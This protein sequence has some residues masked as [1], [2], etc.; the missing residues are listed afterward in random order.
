MVNV[1]KMISTIRRERNM[2]QLE[3]SALVGASKQAISNYE[4]GIREPDYA[5]LEAIADALN[6]PVSMLI[7]RERQQEALQAIYN[8]YEPSTPRLPANLRPISNMRRQ[9]VPLI[10]QVAAGQPI[11]A[12]TDYET[13]VDAPIDCDVA[14]EVKGDSMV[15][16]YMPGDTVYIKCRP[17]VNEGQVA[18]VLIDDE[19]TLKHV[20]KRPTGLTLISDNPEYAPIMV[21]ADEHEYIAIYGV[22]VGFTRIFKNTPKPKKKR[23]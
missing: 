15:P 5:T 18:V 23:K 19:A 6:V 17:D 7:S 21:E 22:P 11:L 1:G 10:G 8:T 9:R 4:R 2:S 14:L 12:E 3:L 20:Y 16:T 13:Y